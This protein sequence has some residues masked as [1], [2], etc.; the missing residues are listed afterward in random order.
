METALRLKQAHATGKYQIRL[1][2]KILFE[3]LQLAGA[4]RN[5]DNSSMQS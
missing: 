3:D 1:F 4:P 5:M 2:Q